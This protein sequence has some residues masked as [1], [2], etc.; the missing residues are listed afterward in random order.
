MSTLEPFSWDI[1]PPGCD[2]LCVSSLDQIIS[3]LV[4]G[5]QFDTFLQSRGACKRDIP[6]GGTDATH[7]AVLAETAAEG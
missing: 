1:L 3:A 7:L 5:L 6:Y 2:P 4:P